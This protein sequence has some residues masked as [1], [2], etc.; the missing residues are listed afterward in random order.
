LPTE[1]EWEYAARAGSDTRFYFGD[2]LEC[3][4]NGGYC[5]ILNLYM[6]YVGNNPPN[7][8]GPNFDNYGTK[9]VGKKLPNSWGLYDMHGNVWEW[10]S[11]WYGPYTDTPQTDPPGP[12]TG[13]QKVLRGGRWGAKPFECRSAFRTYTLPDF[14]H[15]SM[16]FRLVKTV[17]PGDINPPPPPPVEDLPT[18]TLDLPNLIPG[19]LPLEM[20]LVPEGSFKMGV[21]TYERGKYRDEEPQHNV[22]I[23][24][25]FYIGK[26][27]VTQAQWL[28][29]MGSNPSTFGGN[30]DNPVEMV[31]WIDVQIFIS[32]L[33]E[34]GLGVFR[35]PTEAEW[36]YA[37]RAGTT[38]RFFFGDALD[39]VDRGDDFC[40]TLDQY[41]WW[42]GNY[43]TLPGNY[44][45]RSVG[46]KLPN[47]WGLYDVH[48]NVWEWTADW[49]GPYS[50]EPQVDPQGPA[51]GVLKVIRG[52][53]F[54]SHARYV[55]AGFR[56]RIWPG[57]KYSRIG[58]RLV[59]EQD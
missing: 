6:W 59:R 40:E 15:I 50:D 44:G 48:G 24:K 27:E 54:R 52:G 23:S 58:F 13:F 38:T 55:R 17:E 14:R 34:L 29:I 9:P 46:L 36:E 47:S 26:Y 19:A 1:A 5:Y 45:T 18:I 53:M 20:I 10:C 22:T 11:D 16:G 12:Q 51:E 4:D 42:R 43:F 41:S 21:G 33:N 2:A 32:A 28:S 8:I 35:L 57:F 37:C 39:C 30:P 25:S 3:N 49:Y 31:S 56:D 7:D